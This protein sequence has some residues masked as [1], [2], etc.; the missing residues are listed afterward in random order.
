MEK[1][2]FYDKLSDLKSGVN[3]FF[4]II[5]KDFG[6]ENVGFKIHF[7]EG[8]NDTHINPKLLSDIKKYFKKPKFVEC[9][10]LYRGTRTR[11]TDHLITAK[12]HGFDFIEI[13]ILDGEWGEETLEVPIK[14]KN[15]KIAK[16]GKGLEKYKKLVALTHFKGHRMSGFGGA[17][18]NVGMGL[19]S[20]GGKLDMH[21]SVS[22]KIDTG[23][24]V[25]CGICV[26]NCPTGGIQLTKKAKINQEKCIGCAMCIAIC[27]NSAINTDFHNSKKLMEKMAE[28]TLAAIKGR[29]WWYINFLTNITH[30]CD[31]KG[32]KQKPFMKDIGILLSKDPVAIDQASLDLVI[33]NTGFDPFKR[34][35]GVDG[36][37]ILEYGE[38]IGLGKRKYKIISIKSQS[39]E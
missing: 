19:G 28:Y 21:S 2:Y 38:E 11:K 15:T 33:K 1:V 14:T 18:K 36:S 25:S 9:N 22:P 31:C 26:K 5:S 27:P 35:H 16:L 8:E 3:R 13:D 20:R 39:G 6:K 17:I 29:K 34:E 10:V 23:S 32:T 7:G 30:L 24:C 37:Y 4:E 12:K